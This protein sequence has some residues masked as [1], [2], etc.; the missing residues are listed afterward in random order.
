MAQARSVTATPD[1]V[2]GIGDGGEDG[3]RRRDRRINVDALVTL[4]AETR[5]VEAIACDISEGGLRIAVQGP[6]PEGPITVKMVGLPIFAGEVRWRDADHIGVRLGKPIST[7][8]L[9]T[10]LRVHGKR[11]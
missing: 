8:I 1:D 2:E 6:P 11:R 5:G 7:D 9:A 4:H 3:G 10:W